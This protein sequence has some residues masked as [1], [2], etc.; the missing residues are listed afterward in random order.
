ML[1]DAFDDS[2]DGSVVATFEAGDLE[3]DKVGMTRSKF[4]GP[5]LMVGAGGV[6]IL[7]DVADV[8]RMGDHS[9]ANLIAKEAVEQVFV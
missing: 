9:S 7:P 6:T 4:C 2:V 3:C 8:Q 5:Y 1:D